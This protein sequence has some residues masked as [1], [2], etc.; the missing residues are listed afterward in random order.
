MGCVAAN[1]PFLVTSLLVTI[2]SSEK[3]GDLSF[4]LRN[5]IFERFIIHFFSI[6]FDQIYSYSSSILSN[7]SLV[8]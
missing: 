3:I 7:I 5:Q 2:V 6:E 1:A 4:R 8:H